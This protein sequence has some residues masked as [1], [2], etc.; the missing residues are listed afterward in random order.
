MQRSAQERICCQFRKRS[1]QST[2]SRRST[3]Y[4]DRGIGSV[5]SARSADWRIGR[6][7]LCFWHGRRYRLVAWCVMLNHIHVVFRLFPR[8]ELAKVVR[9]WKSFT[10]RSANRI[11]GRT[12][13]FGQ[14][15][16]YDRLIREE[17]ELDR[18]IELCAE[19]SR[20][21]WADGMEMGVECGRGR[22]HD[23]RSGDRRYN[24][25][26][27]SEGLSSLLLVA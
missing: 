13:A 11:L 12:G 24:V 6:E 2:A 16:Y 14:R 17:G 23:S 26:Q 1:L 25:A 20:A 19:Q 15:E 7:R 27:C 9:S 3:R 22:P 21:S 5:F 18:A 4:F 8:Q 10:A